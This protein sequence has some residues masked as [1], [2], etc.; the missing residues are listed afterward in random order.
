[1]TLESK[2]HRSASSPIALTIELLTWTL[3]SVAWEWGLDGWSWL[4]CLGRGGQL[5][6]Q[7]GWRLVPLDAH[8]PRWVGWS[9]LPSWPVLGGQSRSGS[10]DV[11]LG[12]PHPH[13]VITGKPC[14]VSSVQHWPLLLWVWSNYNCAYGW[15]VLKGFL[16]FKATAGCLPGPH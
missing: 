16:Q 1:M 14:P 7:G 8:A 3:L 10:G 15:V 6:G 2:A 9:Y 13:Y 11:P 12:W 5:G 4:C